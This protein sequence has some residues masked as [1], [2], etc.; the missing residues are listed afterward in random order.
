MTNRHEYIE[1]FKTKLDE[2]DIEIDELEAK[3]LKARSEIKYEVEDQLTSLR[4][5]RDLARLKMAEV[6]DA[7]E[8]AWVDIKEGADEAWGSLKEAIEKAWSHYK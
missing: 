3:A 7:S 1:K 6:K 2:W 5:K 4:L 8:E